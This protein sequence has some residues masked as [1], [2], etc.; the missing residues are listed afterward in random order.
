[1]K[2]LFALFTALWL[3]L[4]PALATSVTTTGAGV[5]TSSATVSF[6]QFAADATNVQTYTFSA[7]NIGT[8]GN[9]RGIAVVA[10]NNNAALRTVSSI[11][12]DGESLALLVADSEA[13]G[14]D[15]LEIWAGAVG[16]ANATGD[17]VITFSGITAGTIIAVWELHGVNSYTPTATDVE[18]ADNTAMTAAVNAG[19]IAL[20]A[21]SVNASSTWT[22][23]GDVTDHGEQTSEVRSVSA[24]SA[25]YAASATA[26]ATADA[27]SPTQITS[28]MATLR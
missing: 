27:S 10:Y 20:A 17:I 13:S 28:V 14:F 16:T 9:N 7:A 1:M 25:A 12:V 4:A 21:S 26:T 5:G 8:P 24:A 2:K 23:T 18:E 6:L 15:R 22:W 19:G 11:T 3:G